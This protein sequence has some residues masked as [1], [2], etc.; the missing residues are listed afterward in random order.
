MPKRILKILLFTMVVAIVSLSARTE[1]NARVCI[2]HIGGK[3]IFWSGSIEGDLS[4]D[5]LGDY[6]LEPKF[7]ELR[8][9]P[10]KK[11]VLFCEDPTPSSPQPHKT[12]KVTLSGDQIVNEIVSKK[13][14]WPQYV[15]KET[16]IARMTLVNKLSAGQLA[17]LDALC[18]GPPWKAM[19]FVPKEFEADVLLLRNYP[20]SPIDQVTHSCELLD[21]VYDNLDWDIDKPQTKEYDC[22]IKK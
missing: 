1:V 8:T 14:I 10:K 19:Y 16:G 3:C 18:G 5:T 12:E 21:I 20:A 11:G 9:R 17:K 15:N 7:F 22:K 13:R 4:A 6:E 2:I